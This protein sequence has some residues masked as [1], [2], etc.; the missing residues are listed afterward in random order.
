MQQSASPI[1]KFAAAFALLFLTT[2]LFADISPIP[3]PR[4]CFFARGPHGADPYINV[5]YP[6]AAAYY[7]SAIFSMPKGSKLELAGEFAY[8]RYQSLISYD[9]RGRPVESVADYLIQPAPGSSN[10]FVA[11]AQRRV[12]KRSYALEVLAAEPGAE[13]LKEGERLQSETR[14]RFYAPPYGPGQQ[15]ILYRIYVPDEGL[16]V[17]A[18]VPLPEPVLTLSDGQ[19]L[20]GQA[21][22]DALMTDQHLALTPD[23]VGIPPGLYR[24]LVGQTDKPDTW[25]AENPPRWYVQMDRESLI[26]IYTGEMTANPRRSEGGFYPNPDN[27]YVRTIVNRKHGTVFVLRGKMP[28]IHATSQRKPVMEHGELRYWSLCS[29]QGLANTRV[30][31]CLYDEQVPLDADGY[32]TIMISRAADRPRNAIPECG[33]GW[34]PMADDGDG[35]VDEDVTVVQI[36]NMLADPDFAHA[37]QRVD[38]IGREAEV[39]GEYLPR[40]FYMMPNMVES[41][42]PCTGQH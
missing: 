42:F 30:N 32:Y 16:D 35:L 7:W 20:T 22:C 37:V 23:A 2:P 11:G 12:E 28:R 36:R 39:M 33:I 13:Q 18:G 41:L 19:V 26:G 1:R 34:L 3:G 29:N 10:P 15:S 6:D 21:A 14:R 25:P 38:K 5:A 8:A 27:N 40:S 31:D 17:N 9:G 24:K 4:S